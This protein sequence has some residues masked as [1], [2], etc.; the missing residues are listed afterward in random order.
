M[1][2]V[3]VG[4]VRSANNSC[5]RLCGPSG[6]TL[7]R[8]GQGS[9]E[10]RNA[11]NLGDLASYA[12]VCLSV[13]PVLWGRRERRCGPGPSLRRRGIRRCASTL[14]VARHRRRQP[15]H[16]QGRGR[17][18]SSIQGDPSS[19]TC[20]ASVAIRTA[21]LGRCLLRWWSFGSGELRLA[22]CSNFRATCSDDTA[23]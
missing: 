6:C 3:T 1:Q 11:M 13:L 15:L 22:Q 10:P 12:R 5:R 21:A 2:L 16:G 20:A 4:H 14:G 9:A 18:F 7:Y 23:I 8:P 19:R 17:P